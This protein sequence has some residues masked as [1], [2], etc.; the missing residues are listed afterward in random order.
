MCI[1]TWGPSLLYQCALD[2][3][4]NYS[5]MCFYSSG[6]DD[7]LPI[8]TYVIVKAALPQLVS[9]CQA[10]EEFIHERFAAHLHLR[11]S[12]LSLD[13]QLSNIYNDF[14]YLHFPPPVFPSNCRALFGTRNVIIPWR[15]ICLKHKRLKFE[16]LCSATD[17]ANC[18]RLSLQLAQ[19]TNCCQEMKLMNLMCFSQHCNCSSHVHRQVNV[20]RM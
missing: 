19:I 12:N 18:T 9:E 6:C 3:L 16:A 5:L 14:K 17:S 7:L 20:C 13:H 11:Q 2:T 4:L 8:L 1:V 15:R 10:M